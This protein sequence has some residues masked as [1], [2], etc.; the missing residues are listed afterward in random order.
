MSPQQDQIK[1]ISNYGDG[2]LTFGNEGVVKDYIEL[3]EDPKGNWI[4]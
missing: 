1:V 3:S 4:R 2:L